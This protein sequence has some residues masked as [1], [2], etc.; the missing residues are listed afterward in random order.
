MCDGS[1]IC[2]TAYWDMRTKKWWYEMLN[3]LE[4]SEKQLPEIKE[5]G[6]VVAPLLPEVATELGLTPSLIVCTGALDQAAGAIGVGNI[7]PGLFSENTGA[8][9]A[10]CAS[11]PDKF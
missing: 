5:P 8:A 4:I 11:V 9:L 6:E 2:S 7:Q 3:F 10:I 1:L